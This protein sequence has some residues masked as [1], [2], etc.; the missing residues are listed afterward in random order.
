VIRPLVL[1][2]LAAT[3][4][5]MHTS[6]AELR[7]DAAAEEVSISIRVYADDLVS[8]VPAAKA[9]GADSA[10]SRY[11]RARLSLADAAGRPLPLVWLRASRTGDTLLLQLR[12]P[13][14]GGLRGA[15]VGFTLLHERFRDQV[16][17][18][19]VSGG[20]ESATLLFLRGDAAKPVP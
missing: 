9:A 11:V 4:H 14:A 17:V 6:V 1:L 3:G 8:A 16:N 2:L 5:P 7:Y 10:L 13:V 15:R 12:A 19:R 18:V 20:G